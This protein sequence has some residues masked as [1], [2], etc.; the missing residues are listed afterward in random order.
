M[1]HCVVYVQK[2][3]TGSNSAKCTEVKV[4]FNINAALP[5]MCHK[6][7][8]ESTVKNNRMVFTLEVAS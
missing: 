5:H 3:Y 2:D 7:E 1:I 8:V 6:V 4:A